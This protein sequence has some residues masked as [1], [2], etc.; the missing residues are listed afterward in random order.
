MS[1]PIDVT[2]YLQKLQ[3]VKSEES[4][5]DLIA[6]QQI[7]DS[8]LF[9]NLFFEKAELH[10]LQNFNDTGDP[11]LYEDQFSS[12]MQDAFTEYYI[13]RLSSMGL[14]EPT[15]NENMELAYQLTEDGR[16]VAKSISCS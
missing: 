15:L 12:A 7:T 6:E 8:E 3:E 4:M 14:V 13:T 16:S 1:Y 2:I 5:Q 10:A 11:E 9:F